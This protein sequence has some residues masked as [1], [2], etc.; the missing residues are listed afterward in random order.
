M[1]AHPELKKAR[2]DLEALR[3]KDRQSPHSG[4]G[5][6]VKAAQREVEKLETSFWVHSFSK[7]RRIV[8]LVLNEAELW[9]RVSSIEAVLIEPT[10]TREPYTAFVRW[11]FRDN[12][13]IYL[14]SRED[15]DRLLA[16]MA[17]E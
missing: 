15:A 12:P 9:V 5:M 10:D 11:A 6:E 13:K 16:A 8:C 14:F 17:G 4:Y 7:D 3:S 2:D 1:E